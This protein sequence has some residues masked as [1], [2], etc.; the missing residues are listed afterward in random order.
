VIHGDVRALE[1]VLQPLDLVD[2]R[3]ALVE[4]DASV[5]RSCVDVLDATYFGSVF[6]GRAMTCSSS[7]AVGQ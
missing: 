5:G 1:R 7:G 4:Q 3:Q 2:R 6:K